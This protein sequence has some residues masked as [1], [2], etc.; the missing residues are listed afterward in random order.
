M[1]TQRSSPLL[2]LTTVAK[3]SDAASLARRL[4]S[5]KLAACVTTLPAAK[6]CY[7]WKNKLCSETEFLLVIKTLT[8]HFPRLEKRLR[9]IHPYECPEILGLPASRVSR[10]YLA[11]LRQAID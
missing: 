4:V 5:E 8:R 3:K 11:W 6:S 9:E 10:T 2:V 7:V 1:T